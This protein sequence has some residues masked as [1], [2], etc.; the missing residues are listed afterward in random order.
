MPEPDV[1]R[2]AQDGE[3]KSP[4][5]GGTLPVVGIGLSGRVGMSPRGRRLLERAEILVGSERQLDLAGIAREQRAII[6][7]GR[8]SNLLKCLG[9]LPGERTVLLASGDPNVYGV[10]ATLVALFGVH[11]VDIEPAVSSVQLA[12]ARAGLPL[13]STVLLSVV[14]RP[15]SALGPA[16]FARRVAVLTDQQ[17]GPEAAAAFLVNLGFDPESW[18]VVGEQ[19]G[20]EGERVRSGQLGKLPEGPYH[21]L[22]VLVVERVAASG[23]TTGRDESEY[24]HRNGQVTKAEVRAVS[25]AALDPAPE[26]VVWDLGAGCGSVA[27]E[28]GRLASSGAV[29]A[30]ERDPEQFELLRANL[31]AHGSWNVEAVKGEALPTMG[32][33]PAPDAVFIGGGGEDIATILEAAMAALRRRSAWTSGRL[34]ANLATLESVAAASQVC[35]AAELPWRVSQ[36]QISRGRDVGGRL[37]FAALN[38]VFVLFAEVARR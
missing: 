25:L 28:A 9:G 11:A 14:G 21:P 17:N 20:A 31:A 1:S 22:T 37:G 12:L 6:W 26:D 38:P 2:L 27:I 4:P 8:L 24:A 34:V 15:L 32:S 33:L 29:Y 36:L 19:L 3:V 30:V 5:W 16:R 18:A 7:R 23:R 10:G 13:S 35:R